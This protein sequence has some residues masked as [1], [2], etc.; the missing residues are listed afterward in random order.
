M[1]DFQISIKTN[2][3]PEARLPV[4][5]TSGSAGYD[6]CSAVEIVIPA[7]KHAMVPTGIAISMPKEL[8]AQIRPRSGLAA[9]HGIGVL[10]SPGTIDSDYRGE[11][12]IILINHGDEDFHIEP[13]M[14]IAQ[15]V[16]AKVTEVDFK[17]T[18]SL[19]ESAR[20]SGGFGSTGT[21]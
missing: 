11:I 9:K 3:R 10:N 20:G 2:M 16:F 5:S 7:G 1:A 8:E 6:I 18:D 12:C 21:Q 17:Q 19:E 13:G 15:M 4:R 14:R